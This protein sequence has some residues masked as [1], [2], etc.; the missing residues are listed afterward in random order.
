MYQKNRWKRL[1]SLLLSLL[2]C[3]SGI[4]VDGETVQAATIT[5]PEVHQ[6]EQIAQGLFVN[7]IRPAA[8]GGLGTVWFQASDGRTS[9]CLQEAAGTPVEGGNYTELGTNTGSSL[10]NTFSV[11]AILATQ[12]IIENGILN[13]NYWDAQGIPWQCTRQNT[14]MAIWYVMD[15]LNQPGSGGW[16]TDQIKAGGLSNLVS[17]VDAV[18]QLNQLI[19]AGMKEKNI[20]DPEISV[21][22]KGVTTSGNNFVM[23]WQVTAKYVSNYQITAVNLPAGTKIQVNGKAAS[24]QNGI[25][26]VPTQNGTDTITLTFPINGNTSKSIELTA[27]GMILKNAANMHFFKPTN[28]AAQYTGVVSQIIGPGPRNNATAKL[29]SLAGNLKLTKADAETSQKLSGAVYG[30]YSDSS[31]KTEVTRI[32]TGS[33]GTATATGLRIGTYYIKEIQPPTGY[34]LNTKVYTATVQQDQTI[35]V[36]ATDTA[37]KINLTLVK[38]DKDTGSKLAGAAFSLY[39]DA[40]C[41]KKVTDLKDAGNGNYTASG[42]A[43][44]TYYL[45]ETK[46]PSGYALDNTVT[47]VTLSGDSTGTATVARSATRTNQV[48]KME[49]VLQKQDNGTKNALKGAVFALYSDPSC[50]TKVADLTDQGD[51]TY[52]L[53][54]LAAGTYYLKELQAPAGYVLDETV[55]KVVLTGDTSGSAVVEHTVTRTNT[56]QEVRLDLQKE[57]SETGQQPQGEASLDGAVYGLYAAEPIYTP[58]GQTVLYQPDELVTELTT[59]NGGKAHADGLVHGKYYLQEIRPSEGYLLDPTKYPVDASASTENQEASITLK[60]T[61]K[62]DIIKRPI[63]IQKISDNAADNPPLQGAGFTVYPKD[64]LVYQEDGSVDYEASPK[65]VIGPNGETELFTDSK[66]QLT[67]IPLAYGNYLVHESTVPD[68]H[69]QAQDFEVHITEEDCVLNEDGICVSIKDG[70]QEWRVILDREFNVRLKI[71]KKDEGT[72]KTIARAGAEFRIFDLDKQE[73]VTMTVWENGKEVSYE[74]FF[75]G[76]DGTLLA[77]DVL[78]PGHYR[79]EEVTAPDGYFNPGEIIEIEVTIGMATNLD[80]Y[81]DPEM[82][83]F[84]VEVEYYDPAVTGKIHLEKYGEVLAGVTDDL[85]FI[86]EE[87]PLAGAEYEISPIEDIYTPDGQGTLYEKDG[88][89]Y[90]KDTV[91]ATLI[92]GEDGIAEL[93]GL[94]LGTYQIR[95]I[96]APDGFLLNTEDVKYAVLAYEGQDVAVVT[97]SDGD[98]DNAFYNKRPKPVPDEPDTPEEPDQPK[99]P[100]EPDTPAFPEEEAPILGIGMFKY[101]QDENGET[102]WNRPLSGATFALFN[103]YDIYDYDGNLLVPA[104]TQLGT[105]TTG[106]DGLAVFEGD[107]PTH[108]YMPDAGE[109]SKEETEKSEYYAVEQQAPDGYVLNTERIDGLR[110]HYRGQDMP[111]YTIVN[112]YQDNDYTKVS[113]EKFGATNS[114]ILPGAHLQII[115][116]QLILWNGQAYEAGDVILEFVSEA[117]SLQIDRLPEG[118]YLLHETAAP[119]GYQLAEDV[120]FTVTAV[121]EI[122]TVSMYDPETFGQLDV[123]KTDAYSGKAMEGIVFEIRFGEDVYDPEGNLIHKAGEIADTLKTDPEGYAISKDLPIAQYGENGLMSYITYQLVET[124]TREGYVLDTEPFDFQFTYL[125]DQTPVVHLHADVTNEPKFGGITS[126][127]ED[128]PGINLGIM[129]VTWIS[130]LLIAAGLILFVSLRLAS[131]HKKYHK[132]P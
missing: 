5:F 116:E 4:L 40:A 98:P 47:R 132:A 109:N 6:D 123:K 53:S 12:I 102:D 35:A 130:V 32:T 58:D 68:E 14:Q 94:P 95:E 3:I 41:S 71:V 124:K 112:Q 120:E 114:T 121:G 69:F 87:R 122:Q 52:T 13:Q 97:D 118:N 70:P 7:Y 25:L 27:E 101:S 54:G 23:T 20:A 105:A 59:A 117:S 90:K 37:Q 8:G 56:P 107:F 29:P 96:K 60:A 82:D 113:I 1:L 46:A 45:K 77:P 33:D 38:T 36:S 48:Q 85:E 62:E 129:D 127:L 72:G 88:I 74:T 64:S 43:I 93:D 84:I 21:A 65:A 44:G 126:R 28:T 92:T 19:D 11:R 16:T 34:A 119:E 75:T 39:S 99:E 104:N 10:Y 42:L 83:A 81:Y 106:A 2:L 79:L 24:M 30:I 128:H 91:I 125:D 80:D 115:T 18:G 26:S 31:C 108:F 17:G 76:E 55:T 89:Q 111:E 15:A 100:D 131:R 110:F 57:D 50:N 22:Y 63:Q 103:R 86:W 61:V 51:G 67:T 66:G 9:F 73:Y 78:H 49:L